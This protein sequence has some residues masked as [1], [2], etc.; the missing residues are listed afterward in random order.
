[1]VMRGC[2]SLVVTLAL[3]GL[4]GGCVAH[5][6]AH[7]ADKSADLKAKPELQPQL[8]RIRYLEGDVR[9]ARVAATENAPKDDWEVAVV[10]L[11]IQAGFD[12]AT[13]ADGRA[14]IEFEDA[15]TV[16]LAENSVLAFNDVHIQ[17]GVPFTSLALL[18]GTM[19][20]HVEKIDV[21]FFFVR[22]PSG[23]VIADPG[24][25]T[26][27]RV[28]SFLDGLAI[29]ARGQATLRL[30]NSKVAVTQAAK[31]GTMYYVDGKVVEPL[32][33]PEEAR[34]MAAWDQWVDKRVTERA[35]AMAAVMKQ[36]GISRPLAGLAD[37]Y[38]KGTFYKCEPYGT[39]W[40]P[41]EHDPAKLQGATESDVAHG[42][43]PSAPSGAGEGQYMFGW[44]MGSGGGFGFPCDPF[45]MFDASMNPNWMP[46]DWGLC[47]FGE[48]IGN[49]GGYAWVAPITQPGQPYRFRPRRFQPVRWVRYG[50]KTG[51]VPV[52]PRDVAGKPPINR[53]HGVYLMKGNQVERVGFSP[54]ESLRPLRAE[55]GRYMVPVY[56]RL[57]RSSAPQPEVRNVALAGKPPAGERGSSHDRLAYDRETQSFLLRSAVA[58]HGKTVDRTQSFVG[59]SGTL[60]A[61]AVGMDSHGGYNTQLSYGG[62]AF[63]RFGPGEGAR[64][65]WRGAPGYSTTGWNGFNETGGV[66]GGFSGGRMSGGSSPSVSGGPVVATGGAHR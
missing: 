33:N 25:T 7:R 49:N 53:T 29:S 36:A 18:T 46:Y 62:F 50:G 15:S 52:H 31:S 37:M 22:A 21:G 54:G 32:P 55:P 43:G 56:M 41:G 51:F 27:M 45:W 28:T 20:M 63:G 34:R 19:T 5:A 11:P 58:V 3:L 6:D 65:G 42:G 17:N 10:G 66:S 12:L 4:A 48:W 14:E 59:R 35:E 23:G 9:V 30:P 44:G 57:S 2:G 61:R 40:V 24:E 64:D 39:C 16:Y 13:G 8:V 47:S 26:Y 38:G 60:Q 1:M